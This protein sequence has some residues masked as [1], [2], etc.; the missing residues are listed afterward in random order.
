MVTEIE[1]ALAEGFE[2]NLFLASERNLD[3]KYNPLRL[4]NYS[5]AMRELTRHILHR[6]AP[7]QNVLN[8]VWYK[9]ET[10]K[11]NGI[12]RKQRAYYAVQGGLQDAYVQNTL[13]LAVEE[14]H[15]DLVT[16]INK[17]SKFTHIEP[18][19]F[20]LPD[21]EIDVLVNET[22]EAV[23]GFLVTINA[24]RKLIIDSLWEQ[25]DSAVIDE[26][27]KETIQALDELA[28]HHFIDEVYT[29]K[30]EIY[31]IDHEYIM[32][33][34]EGSIGCE[35]QWGS[36]SDVRRGDGIILQQS[37]PFECELLS[38]VH[39]PKFVESIEGTLRVDTSS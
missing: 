6:L 21:V 34:V 31:Q 27:L 17:L 22:R 14:I 24:C 4:N 26:T 5:Y 36:N 12:T 8:C 28:S 1:K 15:K 2:R 13:G 18:K 9:N 10:D 30:V 38:P 16:A 32:F 23:Y 39:S 11:D 20:G 35:L 7:N 19:V 33:R 29:D 3:D 25:I 37:F